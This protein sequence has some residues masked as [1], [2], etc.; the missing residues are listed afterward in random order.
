MNL[1]SLFRIVIELA[2]ITLLCGAIVFFG[3]SSH[4]QV[5]N[6]VFEWHEDRGRFETG[7]ADRMPGKGGAFTMEMDIIVRRSVPATLQF[8]PDDCL[9][10]LWLNEQEVQLPKRVCAPSPI[11]LPVGNYLHQGVNHVRATITDTG[12]DAGMSISRHK[13]SLYKILP[14]I[15]VTFVLL[16]YGFIRSK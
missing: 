13:N 9:E 2:F 15:F 3:R 5:E 14:A 1:R 10:N 12:W 16:T 11:V 4:I 8:N 7:V 6:I